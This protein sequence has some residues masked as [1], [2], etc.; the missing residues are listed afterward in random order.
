MHLVLKTK[1]QKIAGATIISALI[2]ILLFVFKHYAFGIVGLIMMC[3]LAATFLRLLPEEL[4]I[5]SLKTNSGRMTRK[6]IIT[7]I[8]QKAEKAIERMSKKGIVQ[9][10]GD[11]VILSNLGE[12]SA[13]EERNK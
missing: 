9:V 5:Y 10:E 3:I 7:K 8:S 2:T 11:Y 4:I 13:F 1:I 6:D 12:L